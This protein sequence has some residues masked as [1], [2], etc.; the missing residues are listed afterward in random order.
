MSLFRCFMDSVSL[1]LLDIVLDKVFCR[2][3]PDGLAFFRCFMDSFSL[4]LIDIEI[5]KVFFMI[6]SLTAAF[7][8]LF[9]G[10]CF[11]VFT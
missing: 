8:S 2:V 10:Q 3:F 7:L 1:F 9:Y 11:L 6:V 5:D 4:F